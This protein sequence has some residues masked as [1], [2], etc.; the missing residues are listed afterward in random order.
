PYIRKI[1]IPGMG[2]AN[3]IAIS[4]TLF[5]IVCFL[6]RFFPNNFTERN[7][8][9]GTREQPIGGT[10]WSGITHIARSPY[11]FGLA[12]SILLYTTTSTCAYFQQTTLAVQALKTS[13]ELTVF[14]ANLEL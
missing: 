1:L 14:V 12:A 3:L 10:P 4:A 13:A 2:P 11:L 5:A 7:R 6:V 8:L 9:V